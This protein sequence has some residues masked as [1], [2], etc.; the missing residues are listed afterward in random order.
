[1]PGYP[2]V[3]WVGV[4]TVALLVIH[5]KASAIDAY[6]KTAQVRPEN[7]DL[8]TT[9]ASSGYFFNAT[10]HLDKKCAPLNTFH[11]WRIELL[12]REGEPMQGV[13]IEFIADMP[14]HLHGMMTK[15]RISELGTPGQY[16]IEG[17]RFHM[18]GWWEITLDASR[19]T[20]RDLAR[21]NIIIGEGYC[22]PD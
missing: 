2:A 22:H 1:M 4:L 11:T 19:G 20:G 3:R 18:P 17:V 5:T 8:S 14:E 7:L 9:V 13:A 15:P 12:S 16:L 21:F 10:Y 6:S